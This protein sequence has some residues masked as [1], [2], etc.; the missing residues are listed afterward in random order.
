MDE[1]SEERSHEPTEHRT[2]QFRERGEVPRSQEIS[3][4]SGL[5]LATL[6]LA[7]ALPGIGRAIGDV[8]F[9]VAHSGS[10]T[11][12]DQ[13]SLLELLDFVI[14]KVSRALAPLFI[15]LWFGAAIVGLIQSQGIIPKEGL[16]FKFEALDLIKRGKEKFF[17][18]TP[19]VELAKGLVKIFV[20]GGVVGS[21]L[22]ELVDTIPAL[23]AADLASTL[24]IWQ[25]AVFTVLRRVLP[26][27]IVLAL[28]DYAFAWWKHHEKMMMTTAEVK[29]ENKETDGNPQMR[30]ARKAR[31]RRLAS[32]KTLANVQRADVIITNPTH[33][34]IGLRYRPEEA[35]APIIVSRGADLMARMIKMEARKHDIPSIENRALA[36]A[37]YQTGKEGAPI[38]EALFGPVARVLAVILRR[39]EARQR[40]VKVRRQGSQPGRPIVRTLGA[41]GRKA[42]RDRPRM[43]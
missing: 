41:Q 23:C 22:W 7:V 19:L 38:P 3:G 4:A 40:G 34:A 10:V 6:A 12:L 27:A 17:S 24:G 37:L 25:E 21:V 8:F 26:V 39:R 18:T 28:G 30:A 32:A 29:D 9:T 2:S 16:S 1:Q 31:A 36:R 33:F 35:P 5:I 11:E 20:I 42:L 15:I 13:N 43:S 14:S